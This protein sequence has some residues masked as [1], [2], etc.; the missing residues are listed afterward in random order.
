[1]KKYSAALIALCL[2]SGSAF[3]LSKK[4][5]KAVI[6]Q[7]Y[8]G[9]KVS[10]VERERYQGKQVWEVDFSHEGQKREAIISLEG[11]IIKVGIDD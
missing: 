6:L 1:M 10:E 8:P 7:A 4:E 5:V 11:E 2:S 3:A 9:A